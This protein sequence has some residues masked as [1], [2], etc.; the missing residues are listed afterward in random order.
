MGHVPADVLGC[1]T[2][3]SVSMRRRREAKGTAL[4]TSWLSPGVASQG[5]T[6]DYSLDN[7]VLGIGF[8]TAIVM[9]T[10]PLYS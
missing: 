1:C 8:A 6:L 10:T 5:D 7:T 2:V 9:C 3:A 4:N